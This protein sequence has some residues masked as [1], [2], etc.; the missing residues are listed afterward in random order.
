MRIAVSDLRA[1]VRNES[2]E[3]WIPAFA[4]MTTKGETARVR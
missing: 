4:G 1:R 2:V 3:P